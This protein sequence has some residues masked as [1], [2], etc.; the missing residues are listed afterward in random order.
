M[1]SLYNLLIL[2]LLTI[3]FSCSKNDEDVD[4]IFNTEDWLRHVDITSDLIIF[5][6]DIQNY[7]YTESNGKYLN[8]IINK[9]LELNENGFKVK[10]VLQAG[11]VTN[12]NTGIEWET[13]K[14]LFS[15]LD[16]K[17]PYVLCAGN[18]DYGD[19]GHTNSRDTYFS[20]YFNFSTSSSFIT[21]FEKD[22]FDNSFFRISIHDQPFQIFS[23]GFAPSDDVIAWAD[24]I[25][26]ANENELG[27]VLTHA[28]LYKDK[29][30]FDFSKY[31]YT[32]SNSPYDYPISAI[33]KIN[34]GEEIWQKLI[35]PNKSL[36]F[37]L[38]GHMD[39]PDYI[40]NMVSE[41]SGKYSCL[42][43]L[44]DTQSFPNGGNGWIQILEFK[45]D[46]KRVNILTYSATSDSWTIN[47]IHSFQFVYN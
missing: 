19:F 42:Q 36:R 2:I 17:I 23:L 15:K 16:G 20:D 27:I 10:A 9:I 4:A 43:L 38:C 12:H 1:K 46:M 26:G 34:D 47:A 41:N 8:A 35:Y 11:D 30:R 25:A 7:V 18:H 32:Q 24:S 40:G 39:Y 33:E 29:E 21:S 13:A 5:I 3:S 14:R 31:G 44:F 28:Y 6:P 37:V 22:K 45:N